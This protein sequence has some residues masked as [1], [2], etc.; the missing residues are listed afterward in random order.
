MNVSATTVDSCRAFLSAGRESVIGLLGNR[1]AQILAGE[2][3]EAPDAKT[4]IESS[5]SDSKC[6]KPIGPAPASYSSLTQVIQR[7]ILASAAI[8][9]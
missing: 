4:G 3:E 8:L 5:T 2:S 1:K 7:Q 6:E 9:C